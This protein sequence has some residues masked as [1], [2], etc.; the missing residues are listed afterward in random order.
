MSPCSLFLV[1]I[2][3]STI[4]FAQMQK[5]KIDES[6]NLKTIEKENKGLKRDLLINNFLKQDTTTAEEAYETLKFID[7]M[8]TKLF[9]N[10]AIKYKHDETLAVVQCMNMPISSLINS[11]ADCIKI[12][13]TYDEASSLPYSELTKI[14]KVTSEKYPDFSKKLK[15]LSSV[16]PFTKIITLEKDDF[17]DIYLNVS[18]EFREKYFNYKLPRKTFFRIF[19]DKKNFENY[20]KINI[21]NRKFDIVNNSLLAIDDTSLNSNS[22]FLLGI[23][24]LALKK[25]NKAKA[26]F[27]NALNKLTNENNKNRILFW[28]YK[29][30]NEPQ[31][32]N[33]IISNKS[34]NIYTILAKEILLKKDFEIKNNSFEN[35][36]FKT[37]VE[38]KSFNTNKKSNIIKEYLN[39]KNKNGL[40]ALLDSNFKADEDINNYL[41]YEL[42]S[43]KELEEFLFNY[44]SFIKLNKE[45]KIKLS[46]IF[47]SLNL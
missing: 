35:D 18:N 3:S 4:L 8:D 25:Q 30:T 29:S 16:I 45:K 31:Y 23:N 34:H 5:E 37:I 19:E 17:Y 20:L 1:P 43:S 13:L 47:E 32:L 12:G 11:Y 21:L 24:A 7:N 6:L 46:S 28:L 15:V 36:K 27:I 9:T 26:F 2:I 33:D 38:A 14:I 42:I 41:A 22:S 40:I 39:Y 10:F 44:Y